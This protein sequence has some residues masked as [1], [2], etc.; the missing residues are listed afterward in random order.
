MPSNRGGT[1]S[2]NSTPAPPLASA[3]TSDCA[4]AGVVSTMLPSPPLAVR[5]SPFGASVIPSGALRSPPADTVSAPFRAGNSRKDAS[6]IAA[7]RLPWVSATYNV[8]SGAN[9]TPVGPITSA[10]GSVRSGKPVAITSSS[11][12]NGRTPGMVSSWIRTTVPPSTTFPGTPGPPVSAATVPFSTLVTYSVVKKPWSTAV[13]SHGPLIGPPAIV[14]TT[15]PRLFNT[16]RHPARA[17]SDIPSVVGRLPTITNPLRGTARAV[18]S[19]T[20]PGQC[21]ILGLIWAKVGA[22]PLSPPGGICTIVVPVPCALV[23]L[24]KL[25]ISRSPRTSEPTLSGTVTMPYGFTS[26]L[27]GTVLAI[28]AG[29]GEN[30]AMNGA[31]CAPAAPSARTPQAAMNA[32]KDARRPRLVRNCVRRAHTGGIELGGMLAPLRSV[33]APWPH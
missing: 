5:M 15:W 20:P 14:S 30:G 18:V 13:M 1:V 21:T 33:I 26:P 28:G 7:I 11:S 22:T 12:T 4:P 10:L 27:P 19:P 29:L 17:V 8:P 6:G 25:L 16:I 2:P 23:E 24:L 9:A 32:A 3:G 31:A